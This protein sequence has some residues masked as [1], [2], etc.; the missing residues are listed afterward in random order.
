MLR[1]NLFGG[2]SS[3]NSN[4]AVKDGGDSV[5][6][7]VGGVYYVCFGNESGQSCWQSSGSQG[8]N[9]NAPQFVPRGI[10]VQGKPNN[11]FLLD[12]S[13]QYGMAMVKSR[14]LPKTSGGFASNVIMINAERTKKSVVAL[15]RNPT[16]DAIAKDH[17]V[18]MARVN[19]LFHAE[20]SWVRQ[21]VGGVVRRLGSN[22]ARGSNLYDIQEGLMESIADK[23]NILDR[24]YTGVGIGTHKAEDG[25]LYLCQ[26]F[27]G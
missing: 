18:V 26:I 17:A 4:K 23:N 16:L 1:R 24:R 19:R 10:T 14:K 11:A 7:S 6:D 12:E 22:V 2:G 9:L 8:H 20:L 5:F 15:A 21:D 3:N 25:T 13:E 27:Q